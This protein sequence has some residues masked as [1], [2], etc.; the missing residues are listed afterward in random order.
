[1]CYLI[2]SA[3][4]Y[5]YSGFDPF[6][7]FLTDC[8]EHC[9][10]TD[11]D[12]QA[13]NSCTIHMVKEFKTHVPSKCQQGSFQYCVIAF[14]SGTGCFYVH[15]VP[16]EK[17]PRI[18][19]FYRFNIGEQCCSLEQVRKSQFNNLMLSRNT[20]STFQLQRKWNSSPF[21]YRIKILTWLRG[22]YGQN[23]EFFTTPLSRK[24]LEKWLLK[25]S[26]F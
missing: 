4:T 7:A 12:S 16:W 11:L 15:V 17:T 19:S 13:S 1:M 24:F 6:V 14:H 8:C 26:E 18:N 21:I 25:A 10:G 23:Y 9:L 2:F 3:K 22:F 20:L 5:V